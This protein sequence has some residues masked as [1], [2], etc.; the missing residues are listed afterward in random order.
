[1]EL[2]RIGRSLTQ[3]IIDFA[4]TYAPFSISRAAILCREDE[5]VE[6]VLASRI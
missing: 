3:E 6:A 5:R 4:F 2:V 1:M